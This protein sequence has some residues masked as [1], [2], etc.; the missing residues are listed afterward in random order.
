VTDTDR[1]PVADDPEL[2]D[3]LCRPSE[4]EIRVMDAW[5]RANNYLTAGQIYLMANLLLR[6]PLTAEHMD[7]INNARRTPPGA[8]DLT[9]WCQRRL[10][11]H[12]EHVVGYLE[13][14]PDISDWV[15]TDPVITA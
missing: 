15:L 8:S 3:R 13:D 11:A 1:R 4:D 7:A 10:A 14:L 12:A 5:W 6:E 9:A 2:L